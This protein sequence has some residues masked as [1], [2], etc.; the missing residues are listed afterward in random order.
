M[1]FFIENKVLKRYT[2]ER[3]VSE[4]TIPDD[5]S[6]ISVL[7]FSGCSFITHVFIPDS[8]RKIGLSVFRGCEKLISVS[9]PEH[10]KNDFDENFKVYGLSDKVK[11]T[12]RPAP[13]APTKVTPPPPPAPK[14]QEAKP[15][16]TPP[17][18]KPSRTPKKSEMEMI[19][20]YYKVS[21]DEDAQIYIENHFTEFMKSLIDKQDSDFIKDIMEHTNF[22]TRENI[23][24]LLDYATEKV[25]K[26]GSFEIQFL[27]TTHKAK[28][29]GLLDSSKK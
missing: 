6:I 1:S 13:S 3:G 8:V 9:I 2:P 26:G 25:K 14:P 5:V 19:F 7:A 10:L 22:L 27:L 20:L 11:I 28:L 24:E 29:F 4:V 18:Q 12:V 23:D 21:E 17:K 16:P 15:A